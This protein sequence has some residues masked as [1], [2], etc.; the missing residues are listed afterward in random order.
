[1]NSFFRLKLALISLLLFTGWSKSVN[2]QVTVTPDM[3]R[4]AKAMG[5]SDAQID[6]VIHANGSSQSNPSSTSALVTDTVGRNSLQRNANAEMG[7]RE[8]SFMMN[9]GKTNRVSNRSDS[10]NTVFGQEIFS[11]ENL[12]F[13]PSYNIATPPNYVLGPGDEVIIEVWG[14]SEFRNQETIS[15]EGS[16]SIQG[17]GPISLAGLTVSEAQQLIASK[18]SEIM[19]GQ[20]RVS[21]GRIRSIKVNISGEVRVPGTYTLPSLA[22]LFNALYASGGVNNIG[23]LRHVKVYRN[24]KEVA[25]LDVYDYLINGKYET[26][27]RLED[28]DMIIVPPYENHVQIQGKVKRGMAYDMKEGETLSVLIDYSGGFTGDAYS[29][30]VTVFRKS[31]GSRLEILT[32]DRPD[33]SQFEV[34]D[35]DSVSVGEVLPVYRNLISISGAVWRPG[36]YE[37]SDKVSTLSQLIAKAE[38][39]KGSEFAS[40]GQISRYDSTTNLYTVIPFDVREV[41]KGQDI[42]LYNLDE[43]YIPNVYDLHEDYTVTV[44]GEVNAPNTIAYRKGMT[45]EDVI[46]LC[47]GLRESAS[48]AKVEI[49]RRVKD[50]QSTTYTP[51]TAEVYTFDITED[52][53]IAPEDARFIIQPFDEIIVRRS[54]GYSAQQKV[55]VTGQVLF[56][57]GY[58]LA[59]AGSRLSDVIRSAGGFTPEAYVVGASVQRRMTEDQK[60]R[61]QAVLDIANSN[62]GKDSIATESVVIPEYYPVGV[63]VAKAVQD[64]GCADDI[65]LREGDRIFVPKYIGTVSISGAVLYQNTVVYDQ[66]KFKE[67]IRQA[68]GY[69]KEARRRPFVVYMNGKVAATRGALFFKRYP[70]VEAGCQIIVPMKP[71]RTGN[72]LVNTMGFMSSTAS[73][74]AM[75]ASIINLSK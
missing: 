73:L 31:N 46:L 45:V 66:K 3:V 20:V 14:E 65:I 69:K 56:E 5:A 17:V 32:V 44:S 21:L 27:I 54:P 28:N 30:N 72:G 39:L 11:T 18:I 42:P 19:N 52:L 23:S 40:R 35:G 64:P 51:K 6:A 38:G 47:G 2:A 34:Q 10:T 58:V 22:T 48:M 49:A 53:K 33:F 63:D 74:A 71:E 29:E 25:D 60:A 16:I 57:G 26:N 1:M 67:Y 61:V 62:K 9:E 75:V 15:P 13:A 50:P 68:G 70:K 24:S 55:Y 43:V 36:P 8:G 7:V 12:T 4:Q 59:T 41:M 37:L